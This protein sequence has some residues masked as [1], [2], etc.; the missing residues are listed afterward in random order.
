MWV[1]Q[2]HRTQA[3]NS[4]NSISW[5]A[6]HSRWNGCFCHE[7]RE[8][9]V[10]RMCTCGWRRRKTGT[11]I[12][13]D[14]RNVIFIADTETFTAKK[15]IKKNLVIDECC[16]TVSTNSKSPRESI[17]RS[18]RQE[19]ERPHN[20]YSIYPSIWQLFTYTQQPHRYSISDP[21][22]I[23]H[24]II[25]IHVLYNRL[26]FDASHL[27]KRKHDSNNNYNDDNNKRYDWLFWLCYFPE[28]EIRRWAAVLLTGLS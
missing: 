13:K 20:L 15:P 22:D 25:G 12:E 8:N 4:V 7:R 19:S 11:S 10:H 14:E 17:E 5:P 16:V 3:D 26:M 2:S 6:T 23:I 18:I 9:E 27:N 21:I 24:R 28:V 1:E